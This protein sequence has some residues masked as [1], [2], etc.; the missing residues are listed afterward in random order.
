[1]YASKIIHNWL[2]GANW[3]FRH[4]ALLFASL[5]KPRDTEQLPSWRNWITDI[6]DS[7]YVTSS[8]VR[9]L[10]VITWPPSRYQAYRPGSSILARGPLGPIWSAGPI[11]LVTRR[12]TCFNLFITCFFTT[13]TI[14]SMVNSSVNK[15]CFDASEVLGFTQLG[16]RNMGDVTKWHPIWRPQHGSVDILTDKVYEITWI[17]RAGYS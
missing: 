2:F 12:W 7:Y 4:S 16:W 17:K 5:G 1:M 6:S 3:K 10:E 15:T 13:K 8:A 9:Y 14:C 11:C